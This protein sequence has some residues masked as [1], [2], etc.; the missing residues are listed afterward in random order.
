MEALDLGNFQNS[1]KLEEKVE[2]K[3]A[4]LENARYCLVSNSGV[5]AIQMLLHVL[6][7]NSKILV[8]DDFY[9][10]TR[11]MLNK[12]YHERFLQIPIFPHDHL[13]KIEE[14]LSQENHNISLILI[15]TPSNP[16]TQVYDIQEIS[17]IC[18]KHSVLLSVDNTFC[19][20]IFQNPLNFGADVVIHSASK[21]LS[22]HS[23]SVCGAL[24]TNNEELYNKMK[25]LREVSGQSLNQFNL[26]LLDQGLQTLKIRVK[27]ISQNAMK[28]AVWLKQHPKIDRVY[29]PMMPEHPGYDIMRK[30]T[31]GF[32]G[33]FSFYVKSQVI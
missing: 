13:Q 12:I 11:H 28:L 10:G 6:P 9:S 4:K 7:L 33:T 17:K 26:Y 30:Q 32:C 21:Y 20:P 27:R 18:K 22:G 24:C 14:M 19:S 5:S 23:D 2:N 1:S 15:E 25:I 31:T 8:Q 29:H 3:I 16:I